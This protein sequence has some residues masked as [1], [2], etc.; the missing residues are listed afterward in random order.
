MA[1]TA[2]AKV[3]RPA[4]ARL[5]MTRPPTCSSS[6][7]APRLTPWS[8][9]LCWPG[10]RVSSLPIRGTS[11][12][13]KPVPLKPLGTRCSP[14]PNATA[15]C[16]PPTWKPT[17]KPSTPTP[18][19]PTWCSPAWCSSRTPP[20]WAR[21]T[22]WPSW[23]SCRPSAAATTSRCTWTVRASPMAWPLPTPTSP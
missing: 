18:V 22:L 10:T 1:A 12:F 4:S 14:C 5:A 6:R 8:F 23:R 13:M 19:S 17:C 2:F 3:W 9:R 21:C 7:A 15:S 16:A 11:P 20:S